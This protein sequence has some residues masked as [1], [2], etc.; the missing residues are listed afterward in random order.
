VPHQPP[1]LELPPQPAAPASVQ[2]ESERS[3]KKFTFIDRR[4]M[5]L[6]NVDVEQLISADH[7]AR[8]M[9]ELVGKLDLSAFEQRVRS[10]EGKVGRAA[11]PPRLLI[12][13]WVYSYS[14][15]VTSARELSRMMEYEPGLC[16]LAGL[17]VINHHTLSDFR[18]D[19]KKELDELFQQLLV[20]LDEANIISLERVMHDGTKIRARAGASSFRREPTIREKLARAKQLVDQDPQV[21]GSKQ[22]Q[23]AHERA[24]REQ[25]DRVEDALK[26]LEQIRERR[27]SEQE[28]ERARASVSEPEARI[29]KHGDNA[30]APSYNLQVSTEARC[31]VIVGVELTQNAE[32]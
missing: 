4:Q 23:R 10:S 26:Q 32:D 9:W 15:G 31:G 1:L 3:A 25:T 5:V 22:R 11:W 18:V 12:A 21:D 17:Q 6:R 14:E 13:V 16:W 30:Y 27:R 20:S 24:R 28:R 7:K 19:C 2:T 8:G 29:M